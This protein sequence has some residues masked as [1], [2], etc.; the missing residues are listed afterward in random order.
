MSGFPF[1]VGDRVRLNNWVP[2][3]FVTIKFLGDEGFIYDSPASDKGECYINFD[4]TYK[5]QRRTWSLYDDGP[6]VSDRHEPT[7]QPNWQTKIVCACGEH[8]NNWMEFHRH[9]GD[10]YRAELKAAKL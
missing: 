3:S 10:A 9:R 4:I 7:E 1:Q 8:C 5:G 6:A 2:D